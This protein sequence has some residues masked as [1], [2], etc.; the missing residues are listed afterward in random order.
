MSAKK[1]LKET[2]QEDDFHTLNSPVIL[3]APF[4]KDQPFTGKTNIPYTVLKR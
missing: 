1:K 2:F 3:T 4:Q